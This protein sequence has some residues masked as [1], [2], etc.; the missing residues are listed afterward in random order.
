MIEEAEKIT[1][2]Y[3]QQQKFHE[4]VLKMIGVGVTL[5]LGVTVTVLGGKAIGSEDDLPQLA[6]DNLNVT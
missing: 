4:R 2:L 6:D 5:V 1:E 3:L